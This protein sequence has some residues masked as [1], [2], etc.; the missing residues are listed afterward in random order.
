MTTIV[1]HW[2]SDGVTSG[3]F[4]SYGI[5]NSEIK[6]GIYEK[7]F[8]DTSNL[9]KNDWM[10]D[11]RP[12]NKEWDGNCID[13]HLPHEE[14]HKYKL[15]SDD[16]P[17]TLIAWREFKDKI[18]KS[19]WWKLAIGLGGDGQL[20]LM[21]TEVYNE[22]P[23]LLKNVKTSI[24]QSYGKWNITTRPL[25]TL[26]SS[27]INAFL[28]KGDNDSAINLMK[29]AETPLDIFTSEDVRIAKLDVRNEFISSVKDSDIFEYDNLAVVMF[30]SKYRMSGYIGSAL[31]SSL[32]NKTVMAI[33][34]RNGSLSLR[35]KLAPYYREKLKSLKY[36][37]IDGHLEFMGGKLTKNYHTLIS[38]LNSIL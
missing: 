32:G 37:T 19:E 34:K 26:L 21:P 5:P 25:Y 23:S 18:P 24:Y 7:G 10:C 3:H 38:D 14:G 9:T 30:H 6:V 33:N 16:V 17:A 2:D 11:M 8:G 4:T 29:Y 13:H 22:C 12:S 36:L 27:G 35:G 20:E 1:T 28:R 15:I 31:Q